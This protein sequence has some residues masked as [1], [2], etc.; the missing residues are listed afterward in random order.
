[1][2]WY[3][4]A[5][6]GQIWAVQ[7]R[8]DSVKSCLEALYQLTYKYQQMN[9]QPFKGY[10]TRRENMLKGIEKQ[11][12]QVIADL[13]DMLQPVFEN[14][15]SEHALTNPRAWAENMIN[16]HYE[17]NGGSPNAIAAMIY[18][19]DYGNAHK[20][21]RQKIDSTFIAENLDDA[22]KN[23]QAP[24][25]ARWFKQ[26]KMDLEEAD[27]DNR[28]EYDTRPQEQ[29]DEYY[30][31][32]EF[33]EYFSTYYGNDGNEWLKFLTEVAQFT[34]V[35]EFAVEI[36]QF[37][38]FPAWYGYWKAE[39]IDQTRQNVENAYNMIKQVEGLPINQALVN[40]NIIINTCHQTGGMIDYI[41]EATSDY[42]NELYRAMQ[43]L[44]NLTDSSPEMISW[45][46]SLREVGTKMPIVRKPKPITNVEQNPTPQKPTNIL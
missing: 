30:Q 44:S 1:M 40:I 7:Y 16:Q 12:R 8:R 19:F 34:D 36:A 33:S 26:A 42:R 6:F 23:G 28:D 38:L 35:Y 3:N 17:S 2:L 39:G 24:A 4:L 31:N 13:V 15:L 43:N 14:W 37:G 27:A 10:P 32:L 5:K 21:G 45:N 25:F 41:A 11:A 18:H 9:V 20:E 22:I 46:K 29:I